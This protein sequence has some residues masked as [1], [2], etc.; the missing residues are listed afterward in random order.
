MGTIEWKIK[1]EKSDLQQTC[2]KERA[3]FYHF[4]NIKKAWDWEKIFDNLYLVSVE[5]FD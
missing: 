4:E 1:E 2:T 5:D 3:Y